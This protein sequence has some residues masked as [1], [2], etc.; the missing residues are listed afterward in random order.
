L[1]ICI[2]TGKLGVSSEFSNLL[3]IQ[4]AVVDLLLL[5]LYLFYI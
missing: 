4:L 1:G 5:I 2:F 3:F